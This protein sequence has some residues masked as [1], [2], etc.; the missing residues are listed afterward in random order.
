[1]NML[2]KILMLGYIDPGSGSVVIQ[3]LLA[4]LLG[5]LVYLKRIKLFIYGWFKKFRK[6]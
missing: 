3:L 4:G 1:M 2:M 6:S 5:G